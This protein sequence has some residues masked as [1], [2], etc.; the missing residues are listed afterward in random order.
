MSKHTELSPTPWAVDE[1]DNILDANGKMI[2]KA[3][4]FTELGRGVDPC[5]SVNARTVVTLINLFASVRSG[6]DFAVIK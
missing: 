2:F 1:L 6:P 3:C 5:N 4:S